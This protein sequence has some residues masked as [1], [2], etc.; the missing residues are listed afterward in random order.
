MKRLIAIMAL[1]SL[2]AAA[3]CASNAG[4]IAPEFAPPPPPRLTYEQPRPSAGSLFVANNVDMVSDLRAHKVGDLITVE[5]VENAQATKTND[6]K[7]E[8]NSEFDAGI[9]NL[10]GYQGDLTKDGSTPAIT[11]SFQNTS[12]AK[13]ELTRKDTMTASIGCL[14]IEVLPGGNMLIQG[15]REVYVNG[16][17]QQITLQGIVRPSDVSAYNS[18]QS[19]Q[20]ANAKIYYSGRGILTDKQ[21]PG[22][23]A[24]LM[25]HIWPF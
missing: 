11:A 10:L 16:E 19:T 3:G 22:W 17:N 15:S 14:V 20:L 23:L 18:V 24:R 25:D 1:A 6:T 9:T 4:S 7:A 21:S 8:R 5:V 12:D 13:A 2:A